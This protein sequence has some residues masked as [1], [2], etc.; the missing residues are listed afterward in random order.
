MSTTA[1]FDADRFAALVARLQHEHANRSEAEGIMRSQAAIRSWGDKVPA[2]LTACSRAELVDAYR[3]TWLRDAEFTVRTLD[4]AAFNG[5]TFH[6]IDGRDIGLANRGFFGFTTPGMHELTRDYLP[7]TARNPVAAVVVNPE[8]VARAT[9][10]AFPQ[11]P[12]AAADRIRA[13]VAC[14]AAREFA[15][16]V[17]AVVEGE[18]APAGAMIE[19]TVNRLN[20]SG[21]DRPH[22]ARAHSGPW[23]RAYAHLV[24]RAAFLPHHEVWI[25]RYRQDVRFAACVD[26]D[27]VLD[28]LHVEFARF[29]ATDALADILRTSAPSGFVELFNSTEE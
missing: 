29:T 11:Q 25:D 26:P 17:V 18:A 14:V 12:D 3:H 4:P 2:A 8:A 22:N 21:Q 5:G 6:V 19:L 24:K 16:C 20:T 13:A 1:D 27:A 7:R 10:D 9:V 28:A 15:H 23:C